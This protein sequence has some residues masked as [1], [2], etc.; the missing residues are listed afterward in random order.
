MA[1]VTK[2]GKVPLSVRQQTVWTALAVE[3]ELLP[4]GQDR[5]EQLQLFLLT[6]RTGPTAPLVILHGHGVPKQ[7]QA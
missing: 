2:W 1:W 4:N 7:V 5:P 6:S 3:Q